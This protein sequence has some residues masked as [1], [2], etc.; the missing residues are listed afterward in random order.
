M[1]REIYL[2]DENDPM[3]TDGI[4]DYANETESILEQIR[5]LLG[6]SKGEVLGECDFGVDLEYIVFRTKINENE[7]EKEV[8]DAIRKY[9]YIPTD[10]YVQAKVSTGMDELGM[11]VAIVD[12]Y[13]NGMKAVGYLV[14]HESV[15]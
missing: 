8:M 15:N 14:D 3:Y 6:T 13:L 5:V 4:V 12:I 10:G 7:I 2:R 11:D 9:V 1:V